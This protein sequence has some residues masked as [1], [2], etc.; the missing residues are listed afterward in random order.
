MRSWPATN[1][2]KPLWLQHGGRKKLS[3]ESRISEGHLSKVNGGKAPLT[4]EAAERL[5]R[6]LD[7]SLLELGA[8]EAV[9]DDAKSLTMLARLEAL[10]AELEQQKEDS[11]RAL[12]ALA[13]EV[14]ALKRQRPGEGPSTSRAASS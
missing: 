6:V 1:L 4:L 13:K 5:A 10:E 3:D 2:L 9:A 7:V 8:P 14:R 11:A 12:A